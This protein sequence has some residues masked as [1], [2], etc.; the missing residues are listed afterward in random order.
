MRDRA[1]D[2][3]SVGR[4]LRRMTDTIPRLRSTV[5]DSPAPRELGRFYAELLDW[6]LDEDPGDDTWVRVHPEGTPAPGIAV[7]LEPKYTAPTWPAAD[8]EQLMMSHLDLQVDDL[9]GAA[10]RAETL[11]ARR[12]GWR[13]DEDVIVMLDPHGHPFCLF[14]Q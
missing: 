3:P 8:G 12:A 2:R 11:G 6:T 13:P 5:L 7:Q 10:E 4:T 14:V 9:D 1:T